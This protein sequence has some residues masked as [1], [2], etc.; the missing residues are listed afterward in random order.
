MPKPCGKAHGHPIIRL[1]VGTPDDEVVAKVRSKIK[2]KNWDHFSEQD[3]ADITCEAVRV[4]RENQKLYNDV[5][6]GGF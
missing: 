4:H 1:H 3:R 2:K 6:R 5:M